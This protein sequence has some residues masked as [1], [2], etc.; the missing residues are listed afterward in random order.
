MG[1]V[2]ARISDWIINHM[3]KLLI[4]GSVFTL[5][6]GC[7]FPLQNMEATKVVD[8]IEQTGLHY[9]LNVIISP[10]DQSIEATVVINN[11][12][13]SSFFLYRDFEITDLS[14]NGTPANY[15]TGTGQFFFTP[16]AS[17]IVVESDSIR[18]LQISYHGSM[19]E[20]IMDVNM[21]TPDLVE[22]GLF[23]SWY[24]IFEGVPG[25]VEHS[26]NLQATLPDTF[27]VVSNGNRIDESGDDGR[28]SI[29]WSSDRKNF[30][31][32]IVGSPNF[33]RME[34]EFKGIKAES[35]YVNLTP[36]FVEGRMDQLLHGMDWFKGI[37][38][39]PRGEPEPKFIYSPRSSWGY[40][41]SPAFMVSEEWTE[42]ALQAPYSRAMDFRYSLHEIAHF[43]WLIS[44]DSWLDE[45]L[46][47]FSAFRYIREHFDSDIS[48]RRYQEY[49][50]QAQSAT[51]PI[52]ESEMESP[53]REAIYYAEVPLL[54]IKAQ[55]LFGE[56]TLDHFLKGLY[57]D[58]TEAKL[59]T[60]SF[61]QKVQLELG[62]DAYS[63]FRD[64][65][66]D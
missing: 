1:D 23:P 22:I 25:P 53:D 17:Q 15:R 30:A 20:P 55:E 43:W 5:S 7:A 13:D 52:A 14:A 26:F 6:L 28:Q 33:K 45:G 63:Y 49:V 21:V 19:T 38:G 12:P 60:E 4:F 39:E 48:E 66:Y 56:D 57:Q 29:R 27:V 44:E 42:N 2:C 16:V 59:T 35:Y 8:V 31:I 65:L 61:L 41:L 47:E 9:D 37:Y 54:F 46:A 10:E 24:P 32:A 64:S 62:P 51:T 18:T 40:V 34:R 3:R 11:P 50:D 58:S 36:E